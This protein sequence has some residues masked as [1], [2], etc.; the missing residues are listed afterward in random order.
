MNDYNHEHSQEYKATALWLREH[1]EY[2]DRFTKDGRGGRAHWG[3]KPQNYPSEG[4]I[5]WADVRGR[6]LYWGNVFWM[7]EGERA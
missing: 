3:R 2:L 7:D 5:R 4:V 1:K 6:Y